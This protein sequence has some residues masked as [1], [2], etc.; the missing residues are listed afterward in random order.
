MFLLCGAVAVV[1]PLAALMTLQVYV[2]SRCVG[3]RV[4]G[5]CGVHAHAICSAAV[6]VFLRLAPMRC[7]SSS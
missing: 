2:V 4:S 3:A 5:S 7:L 1:W 6:Y